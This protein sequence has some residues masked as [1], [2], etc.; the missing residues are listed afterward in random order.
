MDITLL[1]EHAL[2]LRRKIYQVQLKLAEEVYKIKRAETI[3]QEISVISTDFKR[4][5]QGIAEVIQGQLTWLETNEELPKN[6]PQ[7]SIENF[8]IEHELMDYNSKDAARLLA[9]VGKTID[10]CANIL[11][12]GTHHA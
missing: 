4:R 5:T 2:L 1:Q 10:K 6:V 7:K 11:K 12:K 9:V 8:H 3:L